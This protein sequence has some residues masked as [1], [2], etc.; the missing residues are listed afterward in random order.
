MESPAATVPADSDCCDEKGF[1][2]GSAGSSRIGTVA[3][4]EA[5]GA[6]FSG[7]ADLISGADHVTNAS[8]SCGGTI[9]GSMG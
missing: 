7:V 3:A 6:G 9:A 1:G 8:T 5:G 4:A 2:R